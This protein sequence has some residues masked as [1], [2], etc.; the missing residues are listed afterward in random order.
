MID[1]QKHTPPSIAVI[2]G[3]AGF[4]G[5]AIAARLADEGNKV[6]LLYHHTSL[7]EVREFIKSLP[8]EGHGAYQCDVAKSDEV[9]RV[10]TDIV[11][12]I[13]HPTTV[14]HTAEA[15][16]I[17]QTLIS[18]TSAQFDE[19]MSPGVRGGFH[20]FRSFA[21]AMMNGGTMIGITST[22]TESSV[23]AEKMGAYVVAKYAEKGMLKVLA[24]EMA[25]HIRV[26][27]VAPDFFPDGLNRDLPPTVA[28]FIY[29]KRNG[30][31]RMTVHDVASAVSFLCS[32]AAAHL[33]GLTIPLFGDE[34][35]ML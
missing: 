19:Q 3:G 12:T 7:E 1:E 20:F 15:S 31:K 22:I 29:E 30:K 32:P 34:Q 10:C 5:R 35:S 18:L 11:R 17:R 4:I 9:D 33:T 14:I 6:V 24:K 16:V 27:A 21:A 8:G 2:S 28:Q 26:H 25:P 23:P 13:G